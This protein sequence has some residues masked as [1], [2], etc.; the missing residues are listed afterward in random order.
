MQHVHIIERAF[1]LAQSGECP[2]MED[3]HARLKKEHYSQVDE[4]LGGKAIKQQLRVLLVSARP[5][6]PEGA[7]L[8][9]QV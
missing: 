8:G 2:S 9:A 6:A 4:H 7:G 5:P 3:L 1:Q